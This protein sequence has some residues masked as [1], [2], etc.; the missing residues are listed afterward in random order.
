MDQQYTIIYASIDKQTRD[1]VWK[2]DNQD[3][4]NGVVHFITYDEW[5]EFAKVKDDK[6][7]NVYWG[8]IS[9]NEL[10]RTCGLISLPNSIQYYYYHDILS[11]ITRSLGEECVQNQEFAKMILKHAL[12]LAKE[13]DN[14]IT[15]EMRTKNP[16]FSR[17]TTQQEMLNR[18]KNRINYAKRKATEK[19]PEYYLSDQANTYANI[20]EEYGLFTVL[21]ILV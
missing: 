12:A 9:S 1:F 11:K 7:Q 14:K 18:A 3:L 19:N 6:T 5:P 20:I 15:E 16:T 10:G 13:K 2:T 17:I 21:E 8:L 4:A